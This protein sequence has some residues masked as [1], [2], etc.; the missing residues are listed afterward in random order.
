MPSDRPPYISK[1]KYLA[2]LQCPKLLWTHFNNRTAIPDPDEARQHIFDT[3]HMVGDLAKRLYPGGREVPMLFQADDSLDLTVTA[4]RDLMERRIP[5]FEASFLTDGRYC[6]VDVLVPVPGPDGDRRSGDSWDLVEVKSTTRIKDVNINDVA[7]QYDVL[8]RA[9]VDLNR[10]FVMHIDTGYVRGDTFEVERFFHLEDVTD[11]VLHLTDYVPSALNRMFEVIGG[12]DPDTPIGPRCTSPFPCPL[13]DSCWSVLPQDSVTDLYRAGARSFSLLDEGIFAI[14]DT[15]D[16]KLTP[17]QLI[18]K[19]SLLAREVQVD[20]APLRQWLKGLEYP[21]YH[22]DFETMNPAIPPLT[23]TRPYQQIPFQFSLHIQDG[24]RE[25]P[26]HAEYLATWNDVPLPG[27][28]RPRLVE[29]LDVI[30]PTGTVLCWNMGFEK[31]VLEDLAEM[32]PAR[33]ERLAGMV[34]R[35]ADLIIPFRN[36]WVYHPRQQGNCSLKAVLPALTEFDYGQLAIG[37]GSQ[38]A[39]QYQQAL[40]GNI[41]VKERA[42][43][44]KSLRE[45]CALDTMAMVA[46]LARLQKLAE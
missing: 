6:R 12:P 26:R 34:D 36:F 7:F 43:V 44:F 29:A 28:P 25:R 24:P 13:K 40:Y 18:Q 14:A 42:L 21:L 3:G 35:M 46:I 8:T 41:T 15:P 1:S 39:R 23:G 11:R 32:F 31:G 17:R 4:T 45:Y 16:A 19:K 10:L 20:K 5:I 22:L 37:D 9:G 30:G 33:A 38:A 27:D 2:G